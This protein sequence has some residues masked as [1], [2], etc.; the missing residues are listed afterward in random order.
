LRNPDYPYELRSKNLKGEV[1]VEFIVGPDGKVVEAHAVQSPDP[2]LSKAAVD[3]VL[4]SEF[5]PGMR[6]GRPVATRMSMPITFDLE[7]K[8]L[9]QP[10]DSKPSADASVP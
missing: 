2:R 3:A 6:A 5:R 10:M 4:Q 9:H 7:Y 1:L 8:Q